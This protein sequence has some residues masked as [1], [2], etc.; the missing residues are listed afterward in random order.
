[1]NFFSKSS[2]NLSK[3]RTKKLSKAHTRF[4]KGPDAVN[5]VQY[6]ITSLLLIFNKSVVFRQQMLFSHSN[7]DCY[8]NDCTESCKINICCRKTTFVLKLSNNDAM[9]LPE[10]NIASWAHV[11]DSNQYSST[12]FRFSKN[13]D[14]WQ[15]LKIDFE[16]HIENWRH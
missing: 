11:D 2:K 14:F 7:I 3:T 9:L 10:S 4:S 15:I 1:M 5:G 13:L 6:S 12:I 16:H 8:L